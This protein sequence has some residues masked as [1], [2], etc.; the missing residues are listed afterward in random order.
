MSYLA[1]I[2]MMVNFDGGRERT[3]TEFAGLFTRS[4][5]SAPHV[6]QTRSPFYIVEARPV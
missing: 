6:L 5:F 4:G 3:E 1:D 2:Q